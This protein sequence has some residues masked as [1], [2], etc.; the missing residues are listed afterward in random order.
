MIFGQ[1]YRN[2]LA[3]N[4]QTDGIKLRAAIARILC[5]IV[6]LASLAVVAS[7]C[8]DSVEFLWSPPNTVPPGSVLIVG[9]G[10]S[11]GSL[12]YTEFY[13]P[14]LRTFGITGSMAKGG[15]LF[16][17]VFIPSSTDRGEIFTFGGATLTPALITLDL[18]FVTVAR[19]IVDEYD[20]GTG[21]WMDPGIL[22]VARAACTATLLNNGKVLITGGID[23]TGTVL[24]S[25][26][27]YDPSAGTSTALGS[28]MSSPR[29]LH[30][31]TLL[32]DG[33]VLLAGGFSNTTTWATTNSADIFDPTSNTFS[34]TGPLAAARAGAV[35]VNVTG[36]GP[37]A[38][39]V[40]IAGGSTTTTAEGV[41]VTS[42]TGLFELYDPTGRDFT[43]STFAKEA[44]TLAAAV[45]L[46]N[47]KILLTG[48]FNGVATVKN[49]DFVHP[50]GFLSNSAEVIDLTTE[51]PSSMCIKGGPNKFGQCRKTMTVARA[52]HTA[53]LL[54]SGP[55]EG[56]ILIAGG[57]G[58]PKT[59][60]GF[61]ALNSAEVYNPSTGSS[62]KTGNMNFSHVLHAAYVAP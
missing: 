29:A 49:G 11:G 7:S 40:L 28:Q 46:E 56:K 38:G 18:A 27:L 15:I 54:T 51:V 47:G 5:V 12:L 16:G 8:F 17:S 57:V 21:T 14:E 60:K 33:T 4:R 23:K 34:A 41:S 32:N 9:G 10:N 48:G 36:S 37:W 25:A 30:T 6:L 24:D 61:A 52:G 26:E 20:V 2:S 39:D 45:D 55:D 1:R 13:N 3:A 35:A 42:S 58:G 19:R 44:R 50:G 31:S 59:T 62:E 43:G 22:T 53:T